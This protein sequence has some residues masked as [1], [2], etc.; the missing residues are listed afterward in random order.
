NRGTLWVAVGVNVVVGIAARLMDHFSECGSEAAALKAAAAPP[1]S[2][3]VAAFVVGFAFLLMELVWYRMLAPLLG[4][5]TFTFGLILAIALLGIGLGGAAY[6]FWGGNRQATRAGFAL[7][8][9]LEAA[10]LAIPFAL[11]DRIAILANLLRAVGALL[12]VTAI[13]FSR[14]STLV[15]AA[16]VA[17]TFTLGPTAV[18]RHAGIGAGRAPAHDSPYAL[19]EWANRE[20]RNLVWDADGRESSVALIDPGD[21]AF[22]VNGK[23]DGSA[24]GD[25][26]TQVMSGLVG[27]MLHRDPRRA[28]VIG[29]GT[30]ST[31]GWYG[32]I[33]SME[34]VD[35]VE[36]E[37]AVLRVA[38]ACA[39]VNRD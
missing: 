15:A 6:A 20:R 26:G 11:G 34:R 28:L 31:A 29:L 25:A 7:T 22:V 35:V 13:V 23:V 4:G 21:L 38:A 12:A 39:P 2:I 9:S 8:C 14:R 1:H 10:A 32:A 33:P 5:S 19:R 36:L 30:G 37:P 16:A 3:L 24:R 18:W 17:L 27:A